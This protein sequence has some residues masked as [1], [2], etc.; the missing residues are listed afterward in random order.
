MFLPFSV[1]NWRLL[2]LHEIPSWSTIRLQEKTPVQQITL[3]HEISSFFPF[4][5]DNFGLLGSGLGIGTRTC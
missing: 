4:F 1:E 2:L 3:K 5:E